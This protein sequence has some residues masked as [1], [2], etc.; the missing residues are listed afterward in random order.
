MSVYNIVCFSTK[1]FFVIIVFLLSCVALAP[2]CVLSLEAARSVSNRV[3]SVVV[4]DDMVCR[5]G[6]GTSM[7]LRDACVALHERPEIFGGED[8][9]KQLRE[10]YMVHPKLYPAGKIIH[11]TQRNEFATASA[12]GGSASGAPTPI[13]ENGDEVAYFADQ[14]SFSEMQVSGT[15]FSAHMPHKVLAKIREF[16][17]VDDSIPRL[18]GS[19]R[20]SEPPVLL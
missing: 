7:D 9:L 13:K 10:K 16:F 2:P 4:G 20:E 18:N 3:T 17:P 6:I 5:F 14:L 8:T 11:I 1:I 15:M 19:C 12:R